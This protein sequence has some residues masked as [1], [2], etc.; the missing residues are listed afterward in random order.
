MSTY[1]S[2]G[3]HSLGPDF[4]YKEKIDLVERMC[5]N[6]L[7]SKDVC[8]KYIKELEKEKQF[9][10]TSIKNAQAISSSIGKKASVNLEG[11]LAKARREEDKR[12]DAVAAEEKYW[13]GELEKEFSKIDAE[14]GC[15]KGKD[16]NCSI[17][18]GKYK[19]NKKSKKHYAL[20]KTKG[21]GKRKMNKMTVKRGGGLSYGFGLNG[22]SLFGKCDNKQIYEDGQWK[23]QECSQ[24]FGNKIYKTIQPDTLANG[25]INTKTWYQF[26]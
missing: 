16:G 1:V 6:G 13:E 9:L 18:G 2:Y 26:W 3:P 12:M 23:T 25:A 7:W 21:K 8:I 10:K 19:K 20:K 4:T 24:I 14:N 22:Q 15:K 5:K 17:M 11:N